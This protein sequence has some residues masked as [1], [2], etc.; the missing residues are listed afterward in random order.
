MEQLM[1]EWRQNALKEEDDVYYFLKRLK[2]YGNQKKVD[3]VAHEAHDAVFKQID[4]TRCANCC[5]TM[6]P[7]L[8]KKDVKRIADFLD[9]KPEEIIEN[10]L[11][12][13]ENE[14]HSWEMNGLP[15]PFLVDDKCSIYEARPEACR[16]FPHTHKPHLTSRTYGLATNAVVCPAV[17][18]IIVRLENVFGR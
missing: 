1:R 2:N 14:P 4:C 6:P 13:D 8:S 11:K 15:C 7:S 9:K 5:K 3:S 17:Y 10:Y 16:S 18:H 12:P